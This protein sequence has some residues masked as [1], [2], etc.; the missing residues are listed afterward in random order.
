MGKV[1]RQK[2][3]DK[4]AG[5]DKRGKPLMDGEGLSTLPGEWA[6]MSPELGKP[7]NGWG[8]SFDQESGIRNDTLKTGVNP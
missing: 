7:L 2:Y 8:R 5:T 6:T 1:F 4:I 3:N